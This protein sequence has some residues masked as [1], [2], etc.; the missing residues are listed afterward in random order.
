M[1]DPGDLADVEAERLAD[2]LG[3]HPLAP[4]GPDGRHHLVEHGVDLLGTAPGEATRAPRRP[5]ACGGAR[6]T[7]ATAMSGGGTTFGEEI[8]EVGAANGAQ[9]AVGELMGEVVQRGAQGGG[10]GHRGRML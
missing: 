5:G 2:L 3:A 9:D 1:Q 7:G 6:T 8:L 10:L 4:R